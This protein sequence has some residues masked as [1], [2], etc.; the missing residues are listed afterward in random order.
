VL[1]N[2][3][4][5]QPKGIQTYDEAYYSSDLIAQK[6]INTTTREE[7]EPRTVYHR[8]V[9]D[10]VA[11]KGVRS[12]P[13]VTQLAVNSTSQSF[14]VN[15]SEPALMQDTLFDY[16]GWTVLVDD[17]QVATL[18][19]SD[20]GE[21]TFNVPA[22]V[23]NVSVKLRPTPVRQ[24]SYYISLDTAALMTLLVMF[25]LFLGRNSAKP[26]DKASPIPTKTRSRKRSR[27]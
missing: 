21:I 2:I 13:E 20:S 15:A 10:S 16:P 27:R 26:V 5:T 9:F 3:A 8:P 18:P 11:L 4:H 12:S 1:L 17:R 24:W 19:A 22:G 14:K 23:H 25:A 6:G 7:Y